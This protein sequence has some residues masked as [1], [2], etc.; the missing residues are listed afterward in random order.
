MPHLFTEGQ[1]HYMIH[2]IDRDVHNIFIRTRPTIF[3]CKS[4]SV[5]AIAEIFV[6]FCSQ[7]FSVVLYVKLTL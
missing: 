7:G 1:L 5:L 3:I 4:Q 6:F 2:C